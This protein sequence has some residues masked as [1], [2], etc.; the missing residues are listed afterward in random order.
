[1]SST[2]VDLSTLGSDANLGSQN[3]LAPVVTVRWSWTP[4][5]QANPGKVYQTIAGLV[6][7]LPDAR[8]HAV[9]TDE[10]PGMPDGVFVGSR[11]LAPAKEDGSLT[12]DPNVVRKALKQ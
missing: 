12:V 2:G 4:S 8:I 10:T 6:A 9:N 1:M 5:V 7:A 3:P 11:Q